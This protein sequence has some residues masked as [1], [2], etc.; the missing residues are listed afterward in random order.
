MTPEEFESQ[1][2]RVRNTLLTSSNYISLFEPVR[3]TEQVLLDQYLVFFSTTESA[4]RLMAL[5]SGA[6]G[7][8]RWLRFRPLARGLQMAW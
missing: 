5:F 4:L 7:W 1:L 8:G 3:S 2:L 6:R